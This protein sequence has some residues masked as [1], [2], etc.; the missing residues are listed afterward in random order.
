MPEM[1]PVGKGVAHPWQCDVLGHL[2]TRFFV[3]MFD[4]A[5]YHML[6]TVFGWS[7]NTD[8]DGR[9]GWV[10]VRHLTEYQAEVSAG[11]LLEIR[12]G[13]TKIGN[14]SA[15]FLYEMKNVDTGSTV[16]TQEVVCVL[17]DLESRSGTP[18]PDDLRSM[19]QEYLI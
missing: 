9:F 3:A 16:A 17:F 13:V 19:A 5:S 18:I 10:D 7:G 1:V 2:T 12:A 14:K 6:H 15:T 4:D 11:D 8:A